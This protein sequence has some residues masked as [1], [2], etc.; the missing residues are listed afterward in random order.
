MTPRDGDNAF[1]REEIHDR[2]P[3]QRWQDARA[4][5]TREPYPSPT[6]AGVMPRAS[7]RANATR[8]TLRLRIGQAVEV[9]LTRLRTRSREVNP[10]AATDRALCD[11][12]VYQKRDMPSSGARVHSRMS[13]NL[14]HWQRIY[15]CCRLVV[16]LAT[17]K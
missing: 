2:G 5:K 10:L 15:F 14:L 12:E 16:A 6:S 7:Q 1:A 13:Q 8:A 4:L 17:P 3:Q 11:Q 9:S